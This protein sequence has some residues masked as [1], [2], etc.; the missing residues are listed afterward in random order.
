MEPRC[1]APV[2]LTHGC[3]EDDDAEDVHL[4]AAAGFGLVRDLWGRSQLQVHG[5]T[6]RVV[7]IG[8]EVDEV[9][10]NGSGWD[11]EDWNQICFVLKTQSLL[12]KKQNDE[13]VSSPLF[14]LPAEMLLRSDSME[15]CFCGEK[16]QGLYSLILCVCI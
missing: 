1:V 3:R 16:N 2:L 4:L 9:G 11:F 10:L 5:P 8:D 13:R 15:P 14:L 12:Q 7:L 6:F